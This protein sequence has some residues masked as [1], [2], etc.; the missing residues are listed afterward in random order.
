LA[1]YESGASTVITDGIDGIILKPRDIDA[2]ASAMIHVAKNRELNTAL[3]DA[4]YKVGANS[5]TWANYAQRLHIEYQRRL[6]EPT[7]N[8]L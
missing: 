2:M 1:S 7:W 4:S 3:G 5:N 6:A 8:Q